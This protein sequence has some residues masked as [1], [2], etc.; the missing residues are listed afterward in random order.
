MFFYTTNGRTNIHISAA[1]KRHRWLLP[2]VISYILSVSA[3]VRLL[4]LCDCVR[5]DW[6]CGSHIMYSLAQKYIRMWFGRSET[7]TTK[8]DSGNI[9]RSRFKTDYQTVWVWVL[10]LVLY[11]KVKID[12]N[13]LTADNVYR[14]CWFRCGVCKKRNY[15]EEKT[16][17]KPR[18]SEA[19]FRAATTI[20]NHEKNIEM[21]KNQIRAVQCTYACLTQILVHRTNFVGKMS[22][23][24]IDTQWSTWK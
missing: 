3:A 5:F 24:Y 4:R 7:M 8:W 12:R 9:H 20:R 18:R 19:C 22:S 13:T 23:R 1:S 11:T 21:W 6:P 15:L 14:T 2:L 16:T 10:L 17:Q